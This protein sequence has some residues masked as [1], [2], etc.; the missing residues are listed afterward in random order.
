M[1]LW[2]KPVENREAVRPA[3]SAVISRGGPPIS[4]ISALSADQGGGLRGH[5]RRKRLRTGVHEGRYHGYQR[6]YHPADGAKL[7]FP[8]RLPGGPAPAPGPS[9]RTGGRSPPRE[10]RRGGLA[11]TISDHAGTKSSRGAGGFRPGSPSPY[12]A[13]PRGPILGSRPGAISP[14]I[15]PPSR[16]RCRESIS[17]PRGNVSNDISCDPMSPPSGRRMPKTLASSSSLSRRPPE[18]ATPPPP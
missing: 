2:R 6:R 5:F 13:S 3:A 15:S 4:L 11:R 16:A 9:A 7:G 1:G 14:L 12:Q 17:R 10:A 8:P 18:K